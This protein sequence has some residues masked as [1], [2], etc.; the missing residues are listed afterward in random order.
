M[1][2]RLRPRAKSHLFAVAALA[3]GALTCSEDAPSV[4]LAEQVARAFCAHEFACCSEFEISAVSADR[5]AT[6]KDCVSF[7]T[8]SARQQLGGAEAAIAQGHITVDSAKA[9][10]C[11]TS[12]RARPC[13][14][15]MQSPDTLGPLPNVADVLAACADMLVGH[16]P[17]DRAC[18]ISQECVPG[19]RCVGGT[20]NNGG[21]GGMYGGTSTPP[22]LIAGICTRYQQ[23]GERCNDSTDCEPPHS[24]RTPDYVCGAPIQANDPCTVK[25]DMVAG[26]LI[27]TCDDDKHLYCDLAVTGRCQH[28]PGEGQPCN[29][30]NIFACDPDPTLALSCEGQFAGICRG[31]ADE[32]E[33]CGGPAL[34][35]CR[36]NLACHPTQADGIG[37]C[38]SLPTDGEACV[39]RCASP[40]VCYSGICRTPGTS[41]VGSN[42]ESDADCTSLT[43]VR[44]FTSNTMECGP[45]MASPRCVGRDVTPISIY[46]TGGMGGFGGLGGGP[47]ILDAST[48]GAGGV[49]GRFDG[50]I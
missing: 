44:S 7:A 49:S 11:I 8:L 27:D 21:V 29:Q 43:C 14:L 41:A 1:R 48:G 46:G 30:T 18:A 38:G 25:Y 37:V 23:P 35:R 6:E 9:D 42:C 17:D 33:P 28:H 19:S 36:E 5:Y 2:P 12:Y 31:P 20:P 22:A 3:L 13:N 32:G 40:T 34:P 45:S 10:A 16:V 47:P 24:C 50:S 39:D 26:K 15:S 4:P